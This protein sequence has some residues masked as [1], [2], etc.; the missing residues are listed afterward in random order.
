MGVSASAFETRGLVV[1]FRAQT[2]VDHVS[3]S[4]APGELVV[5]GGP[6]GAGKS[7]LLRVLSGELSPTAG[8][9]SFAGRA[10]STYEPLELARRRA[11][12]TQHS[13]MAFPFLARAVVALGRS[14]WAGAGAAPGVDDAAIERAMAETGTGALGARTITT[15]SGGEAQR[16]HLARA[17][18]QLDG[19]LAPH[20]LLLDEPT[21]SLDL[22]HQHAVLR[23]ARAR[24]RAGCAVVCV[25]HDLNLAAQYADRLVVLA[26]GSIAADGP[27]DVVLT[28]SLLHRLF[29]LDALVVP[30]PTLGF[31]VVIASGEASQDC[32]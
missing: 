23:L 5:L 7:T 17:L 8:D 30:H 26:R 22:G 15:L 20:A 4:V 9:V 16:V 21:A 31:P 10:L 25:L 3:L 2:V 12:L 27:P 14:P 29:S 6:N 19:S 11:V 18:A 28:P 1:R 24:A 32:P 13:T